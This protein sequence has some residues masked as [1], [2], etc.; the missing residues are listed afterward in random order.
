MVMACAPLAAFVVGE[1]ERL[2]PML[3]QQIEQFTAEDWDHVFVLACKLM[4]ETKVAKANAAQ[5]RQFNGDWFE[6]L[7]PFSAI[8]SVQ[9]R[10]AEAHTTT[11]ARPRE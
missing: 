1:L 5:P 3:L 10:A 9:Q 6:D 11:P 7:R 2:R 8:F 4:A